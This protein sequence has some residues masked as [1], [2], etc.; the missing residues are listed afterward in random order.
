MF[1]GDN[2]AALQLTNNPPLQREIAYWWATQATFPT[3]AHRVVTDPLEA[4]AMLRAGSRKDA[5]V[6]QLYTIGIYQA[7]FMGGHTVTLD[8]IA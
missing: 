2:V 8:W 3:R 4:V 7:D 6:A 1:G 5:D